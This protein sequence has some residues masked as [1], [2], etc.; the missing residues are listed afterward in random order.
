MCL[1]RKHTDGFRRGRG[2]SLKRFLVSTSVVSLIA[3]GGVAHAQVQGDPSQS[4]PPLESDIIVTG[5]RQTGVRAADSAAPIQLVDSQALTR[6]GQPDLVQS[7][8]QNVPSFNAETYGQDSAAAVLTAALRGLNPNDTLVL[9]DGKRRHGTSNLHVDPGPF[10]G[11]ASADLGLIPVNAIDHVEVLTD[12]AAAQYGTDAIAGVI[13]II[14]KKSSTA[15]SIE[16]TGGQYFQ[17]D[18]KTGAVSLNKGFALGDRGFVNV[19]L[20]DKYHDHSVQGGADSRFFNPDGTLRTTLSAIETANLPKVAGYPN[21]NRIYGDNRYNLFNAIY[22]AGYELSDAAELYSSGTFSARTSEGFENYRS[23]AKLSRTVNGVT[24]YPFPFGFSPLEKIRE[25]DFGFTGGIKGTIGGWSYDLSSTY[26]RDRN[27]ISTVNSA[28]ASLYADT[29]ATPTNFYD[30][31]WITTQ[32]TNSLDITKSFDIGLAS[33]LSFAIGGEQRR[34]TYQIVQGDAA[35]TYKE[36]GQSYPGFQATDAG[37]HSRTNVGGYVDIA[38]NPV[39]AWHIDL[40]GRYEHYS[41]AGNATVGKFTTRY[42]FSPAIA[43]RGTIST[44][45]RAPTLAEEFYSATNV[46][47]S[48][49]VV[50]LPPNSTA[51][52]SLGFSN[53]RPEKSTNY[54]A[55]F[56]IHPVP[57]AQ[58][59]IDAYQI[60][61][62]DRIINTGT[63]LGLTGTSVVSQA[64]LNAI[65][66]RN[67]T[68]DPSVSYVG[69]ALF[70]NGVNTR[71][72]G[73]E[74]TASYASDFDE[75]GHVDWTLGASYNESKITRINALPASVS[76]PA[77]GQTSL[78]SPESIS[79]LTTATPRFKVI[80]GAVLTHGPFTLSV[81]ETVYGRSSV[82]TAPN[83]AGIGPDATLL[84]IPTTGIT[85]LT[86]GYRVIT[87]VKLEVGANNLFNHRPPVVPTLADGKLADGNNVYREPMQF[88]PFGINGG[89]Y[90]AKIR[91]DF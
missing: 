71:T 42:D 33:P 8:Q 62:R 79:Y 84:R 88:S 40:A 9:I 90:Y 77:F 13:N 48:F 70:T 37:K 73:I 66:A 63:L 38:I 59:T 19:T 53:L 28:N 21:V 32:W 81:K 67:V 76:S 86:L 34:D 18:G 68:V 15:G 91:F 69:I 49:A 7:L 85:D 61:I 47:P 4:T 24:T 43:I 74:A 1:G 22:N 10:Q 83:G 36:G 29:G 14:L 82:L 60:S 87:A 26:G 41:D 65:A 5:T 72:R 51:A 50:N 46:A 11:A 58:I 23:P 80:A 89:Y 16:L 75:L 30:G 52:N 27:D 20:E 44:G 25:R 64:V 2:I 56:V 12:G 57:R 54:S 17:G 78:I 35:S 31:A 6:V 3:V 39:K 45:F 55:G